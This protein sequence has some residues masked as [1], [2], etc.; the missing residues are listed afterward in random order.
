MRESKEAVVTNHNDPI[1]KVEDSF[2]SEI[3]DLKRIGVVDPPPKKSPTKGAEDMVDPQNH[4]DS[5]KLEENSSR[6]T[7]LTKLLSWPDLICI[8]TKVV[9]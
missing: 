7:I 8:F 6:A 2:A 5:K 3:Q 4:K 1:F 9:C